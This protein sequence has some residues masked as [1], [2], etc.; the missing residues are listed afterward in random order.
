MAGKEAVSLDEK[1]LAELE[2]IMLG[3][4]QAAAF[5]FLRECIWQRIKAARCK[6]LDPRQGTGV[7]R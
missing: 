2:R 5:A 3:K 1:E 7:W 4:D 6:G